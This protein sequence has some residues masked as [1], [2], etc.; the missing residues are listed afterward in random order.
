MNK[1]ILIT[2]S[3]GFIGSNLKRELLKKGYDII[4][5]N[6]TDG[7]IAE[8][9]PDYRDISHVFHLAGKTFIPD[10]WKYPKEFMRVNAGGTEK[11]LELCKKNHSGLT[12]ISSYVYGIPGTLPID[13]NHPVSATN[14]YAESKIRAEELCFEYARMELFPIKIIRPFNVYGKKQLS[15]FLIPAIISQVLDN[16]LAEVRLQDLSPRRDYVYMDDFIRAL[17]LLFEKGSPGIYNIGSGYS[18]SVK[19]I[20]E[21][22]L[23]I[24]GISKKTVSTGE[25]RKNEIPDVVA[26]ISKIKA[27]TGW[28]PEVTFE[29]GVRRIVEENDPR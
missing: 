19:E 14:P 17:I 11:V 5:F 22:I 25:I 6:D 29:E 2:G 12:Y 1:R 26:D 28:H 8:D 13:E 15:H 4:E 20:V 16:S 18:L 23:K 7:D 9:L 3:S 21:T 24:S 10:S 27:E